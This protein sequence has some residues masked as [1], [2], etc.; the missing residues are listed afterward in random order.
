MPSLSSTVSSPNEKFR[1]EP[2][3]LIQAGP[4]V[5]KNPGEG[6]ENKLE[7]SHHEQAR[8]SCMILPTWIMTP[9]FPH[10]PPQTP[11]HIS[12]CL[13][14]F[15]FLLSFPSVMTLSLLPPLPSPLLTSVTI[16]FIGEASQ[17]EVMGSNGNIT[18]ASLIPDL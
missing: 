3:R 18:H 16:L 13:N 1:A 11:T 7:R 14:S 12:T 17:V 6:K 2:Y 15:S 9:I 4:N 5:G 8:S 10:F